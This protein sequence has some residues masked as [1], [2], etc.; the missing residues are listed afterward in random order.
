ME[1]PPDTS[2]LPG[3]R[4]AH[5]GILGDAYASLKSRGRLRDSERVRASQSPTLGGAIQGLRNSH[6]RDCLASY[7]TAAFL[8]S[9]G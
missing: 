3:F 9:L 2:P 5:S 1:A 4:R 8:G 6:G 7:Y